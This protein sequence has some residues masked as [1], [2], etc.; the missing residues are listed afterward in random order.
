MTEWETA[1][2]VVAEN[3]DTKLSGKWM[4][5]NDDVQIS[6]ISLQDYIAVKEKYAKYLPR[7]AG[8]YAATRFCKTQCPTVKP[9]TNSMMMRGNNSK[10][11]MTVHI[12]KHAFNFMHLLTGE[13][14]LHALVNA[15]DVSPLHR[16]NQATWLLCTGTRKAAFQKIKTIAECL[17]EELISATKGSSNSYAI[18]KKDELE[19]VA[20]SNC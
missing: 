19:H 7:S 5:T 9:L 18:K 15:V 17:A 2:P 1:A 16:V 12:I 10:K 11:L 8:P 20:K 3:P 14:P 4:I 6:D 13:N